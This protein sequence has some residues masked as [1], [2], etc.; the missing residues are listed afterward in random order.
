MGS[1]GT[2]NKVETITTNITETSSPSTNVWTNVLSTFKKDKHQTTIESIQP[3]INKALT[4]ECFTYDLYAVC[5]HHGDD[6]QGG[7]YTA[8]CRNPTDGQWYSFDDIHTSKVEE[9]EVVSQDAY[10]LFY[11]RQSL[12][13][14]PSSSASSSSGSS[15]GSGQEHWVYRM[16]DFNYKN[17]SS[18]TNSQTNSTTTPLTKAQQQA[19]V[20]A[21][22]SGNS[23]GGL[24]APPAAAGT[25]FSRN[26]GAYATMPIVKSESSVEVKNSTLAASNNEQAVT[27]NEA[28]DVVAKA[29]SESN[30][31][32][33]KSLTGTTT[34]TSSTISN[35]EN[36]TKLLRE[37]IS[38]DQ[39]EEVDDV[40]RPID[41]N[42]VD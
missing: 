25:G 23:G 14:N 29:E 24:E 42:D 40:S 17:K 27:N 36:K 12:T 20:R 6:L 21:V 34:T 10:I 41:K 11:Q 38:S 22:T 13:S 18:S 2:N 32:E 9:N 16:P 33:T 7:H 28:A 1:S 15:G 31:A 8:T 5:N 19:N 37:I 30:K 26:K 35:S 4:T 3:P 39:T